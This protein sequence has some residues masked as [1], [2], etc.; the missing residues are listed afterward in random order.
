MGGGPDSKL[1]HLLIVLPFEEP[2]QSIERIK[3]KFP[4]IKVTYEN[5]DFR[6]TIQDV[7]RQV[8]E[9]MVKRHAKQL[10]VIPNVVPRI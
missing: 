1:E 3:K 9:G 10:E 8:S 4:N 6:S 7:V 5:L 2:T